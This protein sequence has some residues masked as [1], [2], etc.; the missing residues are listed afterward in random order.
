MIQSL[1]SSRNLLVV[2]VLLACF[3]LT[4]QCTDDSTDPM[5]PIDPE[6]EDK[7]LTE[8]SIATLYRN[9]CGGCHGQKFESF[10]ERD[11]SYGS[12]SEALFNSIKDGYSDNGMPSYGAA[13]SEEEIQGIAD[14]ILA[15]IEGKTKE[16]L[17]EENPDLTG[18]IETEDMSFRLETMTDEIDGVPWG[19]AQLPNGDLLVTERTGSLYL[20]KADKTLE[21]ISG[22][23]SVNSGGQG[24]LLDV[25]IHPDFAENQYVY[26]S[27]SKNNPENNSG[28]ATAVARGML[29]GN[30]LTG[31]T[32]IFVALPYRS[33][34][35][36]YGSRLQFDRSGYLYISVGDRGNRDG[37]PQS[38]DNYNGKVHRIHDDGSIPSDNPF[39]SDAD[40]PSTIYAYGNRNPQGL[41]MHPVTGDIW[42]GEHGPQGGDEI[43][44]VGSGNNY[45]WPVITYGIN[46]DG[47]PIT[48][49]TEMDGMEQPIHYWVPSIAPSGMDFVSGE[50]YPG[51]TND[52]F[53]SSLKF[54]YLHRLKMQGDEVVGEE[55]LLEDIGRMRDVEM[56]LDG[57]LYITTESPGSVIRIVPEN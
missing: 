6:P 34:G 26:L 40:V 33:S 1:L 12:S 53:V 38:L 41:S 13:L 49:L 15:Q 35:H 43:N 29:E 4:I 32:D 20:L 10:V 46:Y 23:P 22:A 21:T 27:Y 16:M 7:E 47:S 56:G 30:T 2:G 11:W 5:D 8:D 48:D 31:V 57:Y 39:V 3:L 24:G 17:I 55:E 37:Y 51:W 50:L 25:A 36:H 9:H 45:G 14:Y 52:L 28:S 44:I 18:I 42:E 54:R 19:V